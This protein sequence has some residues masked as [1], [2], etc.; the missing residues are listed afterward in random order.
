MNGKEKEEDPAVASK[1]R[2]AGNHGENEYKDMDRIDADGLP[3]VGATIWPGDNQY[4]IINASNGRSQRH[5]LKG[6]EVGTRK[7]VSER[8]L[9]A[10]LAV[11]YRWNLFP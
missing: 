1:D 9:K 10:I 2:R 4:S 6:E 7:P 3:H 5:A 11:G 8:V